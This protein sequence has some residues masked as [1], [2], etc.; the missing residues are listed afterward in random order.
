M[1]TY[2]TKFEKLVYLILIILLGI[3]ILFSISELIGLIYSGLF[4][5]SVYR[6][7]NH[8]LVNLFGFFLLV[9]IG[10]ELLETL[11]TYLQENTIHFEIVILVALIAVARKVILLEPD[12]NSNGLVMVGIGVIILSLG[13]AYLLIKKAKSMK[14][15]EP[16]VP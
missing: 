12:N 13:A 8:E 1:E 9:I 5:E 4:V 2:I 15:Q 16:D 3:V 14:S 6:L 7:D 10:I 11:K